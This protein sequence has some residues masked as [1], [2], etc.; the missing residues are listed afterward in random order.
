MYLGLG[1]R[2]AEDRLVSLF[3][4]LCGT[5]ARCPPEVKYVHLVGLETGRVDNDANSPEPAGDSNPCRKNESKGHGHAF[6]RVWAG[7]WHESARLIAFCGYLRRVA[8]RGE[9]L[10]GSFPIPTWLTSDLAFPGAL[11][12]GRRKTTRTKGSFLPDPTYL[13]QPQKERYFIFS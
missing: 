7:S 13:S 5:G 10:A 6:G 2:G 11:L 8:R 4:C 1:H 9:Q 12:P 3:L